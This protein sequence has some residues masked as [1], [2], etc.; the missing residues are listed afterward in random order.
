[1][2]RPAERASTSSAFRSWLEA[3]AKSEDKSY[4]DVVTDV[5]G[6][7]GRTRQH[8]YALANGTTLPSRK[9]AGAI[10]VLSRGKVDAVKSWG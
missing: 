4:A 2:G 7:L 3:R 6:Q 9:L 5:A 8:V 10:E 1:M